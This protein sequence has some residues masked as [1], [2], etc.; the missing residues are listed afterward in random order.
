MKRSKSAGSAPRHTDSGR[1]WITAA[2]LAV[3]AVLIAVGVAVGEPAEVAQKA[4]TICLECI[5]VG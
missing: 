5:G 1:S 2:L 3:A 4:V